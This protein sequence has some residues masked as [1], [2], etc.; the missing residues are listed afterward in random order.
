MIILYA[1]EQISNSIAVCC[2]STVLLYVSGK[3]LS[4]DAADTVGF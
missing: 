4:W 1:K 2:T 3:K